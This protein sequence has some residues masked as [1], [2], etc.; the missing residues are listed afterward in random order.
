MPK[1]SGVIMR[2]NSPPYP[3]W[4]FVDDN[5]KGAGVMLTAANGDPCKCMASLSVLPH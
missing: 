1:L 5:N 3:E 2:W 4:S